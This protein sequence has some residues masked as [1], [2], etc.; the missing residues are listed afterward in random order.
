M[1]ETKIGKYAIES[2]TKSMY[3][4]CRCI[5]R[6]YVQNAAD[7]IDIALKEK[8]EENDN[9][10]IHINIYS[11]KKRIEIEDNATGVKKD[12]I[13]LLQDV[14]CSTKKRGEQKGFRGIGRL[15]GL[16]YCTK[17]TFITSAKGENQKSIMIWDAEK[18][19]KI[20]D[21]EKNTSSAGEVID[22]CI[23]CYYESETEESHYFK[24][25][26]ENVFDERLLDVNDIS[27]YLSMVAPVDYP[28][29]FNTFGQKIKKYAKNNNLS[30]DTYNLYLN[31]DQ[32]YKGYSTRIKN[33][34]MGDY[35]VKDIEFF[36][37]KDLKN[38]FIY[39]GWYSISELK[40]QISSDNIPYGIRLRCKNIQLGDADTCR[41]FIE[42]DTEKRFTQYFYGE[43]FVEDKDLQ[44]DAR[45]DYLR[46]GELRNS[47]ENMVKED[48][49]QLKEL[50]NDAS[51]I[52]STQKQIET[53]RVGKEE[54]EKKRK[55]GFISEIQ[56]EDYERNLAKHKSDEDKSLDKLKKQKQKVLES[57]SPLGFMFKDNI[58]QNHYQENINSGLFKEN[59]NSDDNKEKTKL[60][61]DEPLYEK[62][63]P[64][65]KELVNKV[66]N[67]IY[68]A[69]ADDNMRECLIKK[70][71]Q[72]ITK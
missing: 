57:N 23:N 37:R 55:E 20:V 17:L 27:T 21:D 38:N 52:R 39:W 29:S 13:N 54:I 32:I 47:F 34:K 7:Q 18:M 2:L 10:F 25:I 53:A 40:G 30:I 42:K 28:T 15:G 48:F 68:L 33:P 6:E 58:E 4:D 1:S 46:E 69:I 50:C 67:A 11:D 12:N 51:K 14:A 62:F 72:E 36:E 49:I 24:I 19:N 44:P 5:F 71:E 43:L 3:E 41:R 61:T 8:L 26:M 64:K 22:D 16:G 70:V 45:R 31:G 9:Y 56:K 35:D 60:R 65:E 66:Y 63:T 59:I